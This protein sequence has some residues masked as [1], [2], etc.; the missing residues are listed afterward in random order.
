MAINATYDEPS[1]SM[2]AIKFMNNHEYSAQINIIYFSCDSPVII[3]KLQHNDGSIV[4]FLIAE[5]VEF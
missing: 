2:K 4:A 3:M 1:Q 5:T